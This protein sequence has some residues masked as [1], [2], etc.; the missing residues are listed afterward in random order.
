MRFDDGV[1]DRKPNSHIFL[2]V[3]SAHST[4]ESWL[5]HLGEFRHSNAFPIIADRKQ[6]IVFASADT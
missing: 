6:H 1:A 3:S 4:G 5:K 2:A